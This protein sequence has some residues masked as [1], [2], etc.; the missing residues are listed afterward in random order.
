MLP[1]KSRP[2]CWNFH[3]VQSGPESASVT[4]ASSH[5]HK[6]PVMGIWTG[7]PRFNCASRGLLLA[8]GC[9]VR[10][11]LSTSAGGGPWPLPPLQGSL[12]P[13]SCLLRSVINNG[14][15]TRLGLSIHSPPPHPPYLSTLSPPYHLQAPQLPLLPKAHRDPAIFSHLCL[16]LPVDP[17]FA[18]L[19]YHFAPSPAPADS[20]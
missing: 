17:G 8:S 9:S 3:N 15:C 19:F 18:S 4:A 1:L 7:E 2:K 16:T 14:S 12:R 20:R 10:N 13:L 5:L 6:H 11:I